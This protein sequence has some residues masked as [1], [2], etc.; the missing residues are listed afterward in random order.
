MKNKIE[1]KK[2]S[3]IEKV[4][5]FLVELGFICSSYPSAQHLIYIK[6]GETVIIKNDKK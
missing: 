2:S 3:D 5:K 6:S 1:N 4:K